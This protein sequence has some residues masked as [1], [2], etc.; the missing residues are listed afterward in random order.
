M[1]EYKQPYNSPDPAVD[2]NLKEK[3][4]VAIVG[5]GIAGMTAAVYLAERGF[6]VRLYEKESYLGGKVG[7]W[8]VKFEDGNELSVE[9]GFHAFF[10]QYYNLL[11]LLRKIDAEQYLTP[12]DDYL[13]LADAGKQRFSFKGISR[14]PVSNVLSLRK[15]GV[16]SAREAILSPKYTRLITLFR[17]SETATFQK[18]DGLSFEEFANKVNLSQK[19]RLMFTTFSRAFFAEPKDISMAELIKSFH[20]YFLS[21]EEGLVYDVMNDDFEYTLLR[22]FRKFMEDHNGEIFLNQAIENV[23]YEENS[24]VLNGVSHDYLVFG[25]DIGGT[26]A[27]FQKAEWIGRD[28]PA[29]SKQVFDQKRSQPYA[30]LRVWTDRLLDGDYPFFI[31]TDSVE[32]LDSITL[33]HQMEKSSQE[34]SE[35]N[36]GGIYELHSYAIPAGYSLDKVRDQLLAEFYHYF[37]ELEGMNILYENFQLKD[38]FT[39]FHTGLYEN[40]PTWKTEVEGLY[41]TGDWI[42]LPIPAMLMENACASACFAVNEILKKENLQEEQIWTVPVK[43]VLAK[44]N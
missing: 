4:S 21:N 25:T 20:F 37:P 43:G 13:I 28:F 1:G 14:T 9:H 11:E 16:Y 15:A 23:Q 7:S 33:Y 38:D 31:F 17:Y 39:A 44:A 40:R 22:P 29:L 19:L 26:Q 42:K 2:R 34:W 35:E 8:K 24:F 41:L 10:R 27:I 6:H 30:V 12:I 32:I 3:K 5:A 36:Q 18:Y